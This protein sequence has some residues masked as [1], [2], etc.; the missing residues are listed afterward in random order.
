MGE[1][2]ILRLD[3]G[4]GPAT[5]PMKFSHFLALVFFAATLI[6]GVVYLSKGDRRTSAGSTD[7]DSQSPDHYF[8]AVDHA[9]PARIDC[10]MAR[11]SKHPEI[12]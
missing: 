2:V 5:P 12:W 6:V 8:M 4:S 10:P 7:G 11:D 9:T 1:R 3:S